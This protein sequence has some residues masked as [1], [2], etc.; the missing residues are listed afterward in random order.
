MKVHNRGS[1]LFC[2][3]LNLFWILQRDEEV[4]LCEKPCVI[5]QLSYEYYT[6]ETAFGVLVLVLVCASGSACAFGLGQ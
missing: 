3:K 5:H 6:F 1:Q 4:Q 2:W